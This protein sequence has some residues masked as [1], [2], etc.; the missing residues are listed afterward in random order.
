[1]QQRGD[2]DRG[3]SSNRAKSFIAYW[4]E[5]PFVLLAQIDV[6]FLLQS[7]SLI[8]VVFSCMLRRAAIRCPAISLKALKMQ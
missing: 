4:F 7:S 5:C 8:D 3:T 1:L 6:Y 2:A